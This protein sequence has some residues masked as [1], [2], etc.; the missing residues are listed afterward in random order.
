MDLASLAPG[1]GGRGPHSCFN[2]TCFNLRE[3]RP[4]RRARYPR[5]A[6]EAARD[7][8]D[9]YLRMFVSPSR[10]MIRAAIRIELDGLSTG[11]KLWFRFLV[12]VWKDAGPGDDVV[13]DHK[14]L[15]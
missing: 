10:S 11:A 3:F 5:K 14:G 7:L 2:P 12:S 8:T 9:I 15:T 4:K 13:H 1:H 6:R